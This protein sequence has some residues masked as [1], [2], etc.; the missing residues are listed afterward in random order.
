V[1]PDYRFTIE[2]IAAESSSVACWGRVHMTFAGRFFGLAP[3]G[4]TA[5]LPAVS[6]FTY[7]GGALTSE[8]FHFDLATLCAQIGVSVDDMNA[9][10]APVR[11][12]E[13]A[14]AHA[15]AVGG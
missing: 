4:R 15:A 10:L 12:A 5:E 2:G 1:F 11:A 6:I 3:T 8:I 9:E 14:T 13:A 7:P